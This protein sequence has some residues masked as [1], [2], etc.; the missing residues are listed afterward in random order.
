MR[1]CR[2]VPPLLPPEVVGVPT[3]SSRPRVLET[4]QADS[5]WFTPFAWG[6]KGFIMI[7][8]KKNLCPL[9]PQE[10]ISSN[11]PFVLSDFISP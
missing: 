7:Q 2:S 10:I 9:I 6:E 3:F 1:A 8:L 4:K 11:Q 5:I